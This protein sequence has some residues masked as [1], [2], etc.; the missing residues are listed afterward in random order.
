[1]TKLPEKLTRKALKL[2]FFKL[3]EKT[4][5]YLFDHERENGLNA[6]RTQGWGVKKAFYSTEKIRDWLIERNYYTAEDFEEKKP[7]R[8]ISGNWDALV[9]RRHAL[10]A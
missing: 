8:A 4:W 1:M 6:C 2:N 3:S 10:T 5:D 9:S 7:A